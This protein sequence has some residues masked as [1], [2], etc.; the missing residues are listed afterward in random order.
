MQS[1]RNP[2]SVVALLQGNL[3][4]VMNFKE[5]VGKKTQNFVASRDFLH[6][7]SCLFFKSTNIYPRK[8]LL[9]FFVDLLVF[10]YELSLTS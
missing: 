9:T 4:T 8:F 5:I 10:P 2:G 3:E 7:Y 1:C 6:P